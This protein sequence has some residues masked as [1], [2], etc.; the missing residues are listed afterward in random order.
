MAVERLS[1]ASIGTLNKYS[2]MMA[3]SAYLTDYQLIST[4]VLAS[5][6]A[7]VSFSSIPNTYRHLQIRYAAR[8]DVAAVADDL[9][10]R[11]NGDS[12]SS[13]V[14]HALTGNGTTVSSLYTAASSWMTAGGLVGASAA[15][16]VFASGV[17]DILDYGQTKNKTV[18]SLSG[19]YDSTKK[20][21]FESGLWLNTAA[22]TSLTF[23]DANTANFV[24]GSR[25]SL[26]GWN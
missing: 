15:T 12:T 5:N 23:F 8:T 3:G 18:K 7:S 2:S 4:T 17:I 10:L 11:F 16:N 1:R 22:I 21:L 26:Y 25:F 13:Y 24:A 20:T 6:T 9:T 14:W 19:Y